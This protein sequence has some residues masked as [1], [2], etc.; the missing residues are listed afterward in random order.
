MHGAGVAIYITPVGVMY[1]YYSVIEGDSSHCRRMAMS[2]RPKHIATIMS[3]QLYISLGDITSATC[4]D[5]A[6]YK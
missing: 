5:F 3:L 1:N 6:C 4:I 2:T